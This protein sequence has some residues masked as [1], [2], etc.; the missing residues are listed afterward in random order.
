MENRSA[1]SFLNALAKAFERL[2]MVL[3][4]NSSYYGSK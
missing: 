3:A 1:S 2:H 4:A